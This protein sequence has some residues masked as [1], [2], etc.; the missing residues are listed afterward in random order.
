MKVRVEGTIETML[1]LKCGLSDMEI[2]GRHYGIDK[3]EAKKLTA[4]VQEQLNKV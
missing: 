4:K 2:T 1:E 3:D